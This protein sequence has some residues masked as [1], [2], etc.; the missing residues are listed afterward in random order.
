MN[1]EDQEKEWFEVNG[2]LQWLC[3]CDCSDRVF[4]AREH[5]GHCLLNK[6]YNR[7]LQRT[8]GAT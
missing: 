8:K 7:F 4:H 6:A 1:N 2:L 3:T 5:Y